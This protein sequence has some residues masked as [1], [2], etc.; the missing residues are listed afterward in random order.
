MM[1]NEQL[2]KAAVEAIQRIFKDESVS[3]ETARQ[4]LMALQEEIDL[5][6]DALTES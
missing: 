6:L 5:L 1:R 3:Q 4:T 2:Y